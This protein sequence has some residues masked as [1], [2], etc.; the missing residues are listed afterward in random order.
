MKILNFGSMNIDHVYQVDEFVRQGE[1]IP[2]S[3]YDIFAGGKGLNQSIALA[4]AGAEVYHAGNIGEDG[5]IL[6]AALK[7]AGVNT[8]YIRRC[9]GP[10]SHTI[11]QVDANG[12]NC[13]IVYSGEN[14]KITDEYI[15]CVL[16]D[17]S[18]EDYLILQNE[19]DNIARIMEKAKEKGLIIVFNPSPINE[20]IYNYPLYLVDY[21]ILNEH[22]G[23]A[24]TD[25]SEPDEICIRLIEKYPKAKVILTLGE[26]GSIYRDSKQYIKQE[27]FPAEVVDTT[28]AGD[29]FTG[30]FFASVTAGKNETEAL[31]IASKAAAI[32]ITRMGAAGSIPTLAE[33][34]S[35]N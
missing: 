16:R 26:K 19:I 12:N 31:R 6:L 24:L 2:A 3:S 20:N 11:I 13:I 30:Y 15:D 22:E 23:F 25:T 18:G 21:F 33:V 4:K 10:S 34:I 27:A 32:T 14:L 7:A 9:S 17:F 29:T 1:T 28:A 35:A 8:Q 5:D